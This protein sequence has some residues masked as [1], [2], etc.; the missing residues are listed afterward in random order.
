MPY[1]V[2][3]PT[4]PPIVQVQLQGASVPLA[5]VDNSLAIPAPI[6]PEFSSTARSLGQPVEIG[7]NRNPVKPESSHTVRIQLPLS[8]NEAAEVSQE[9][10]DIAP[11][12]SVTPPEGEALPLPTQVPSPAPAP[13]SESLPL[14]AQVPSPAPALPGGVL[15]NNLPDNL[16]ANIEQQL[17]SEIPRSPL[18]PTN[19]PPAAPPLPPLPRPPVPGAENV[20]ELDADR[21]IYDER[22]QVYRAEGNAVM[23]FRGAVLRR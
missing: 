10:Q 1:P 23:R 3:P 20:I 7:V 22:D 13:P 18:P 16:P 4:P 19:S 8:N 11:A 14:P 9:T 21:Q 5:S 15:P 2:L 6:A 17:P 12:P